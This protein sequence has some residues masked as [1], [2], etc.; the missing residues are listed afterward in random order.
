MKKANILCLLILIISVTLLQGQRGLTR[1]SCMHF[2]VQVLLEGALFDG[3]RGNYQELMRTNLSDFGYL[4]GQ[5]PVTLFGQATGSGQPYGGM[6]WGHNGLEGFALEVEEGVGY[7]EDAVDWVLVSLRSVPTEVSNICDRA[8]V[9]TA[10]GEIIFYDDDTCCEPLDSS[11][12]VSVAHRNHLPVL[13]ESPLPIIDKVISYDFRSNQT[14]RS[15]L[16]SGQK[17]ISDNRFA[18]YAGN[19]DQQSQNISPSD[20]NANDISMWARENG[21]NSGYFDED[22]DLN[23]DVNVLDKALLLIN[24]GIFTDVRY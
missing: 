2:D 12:F 5:E 8:G 18:M 16:G 10:N 9:L 7:P 13:S 4:P 11:Y 6:P 14:Y 23:G 21:A 22:Y 17:E 19:G 20:L 1:D 24:L 3:M 15:I